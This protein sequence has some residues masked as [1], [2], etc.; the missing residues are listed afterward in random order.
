M[1]LARRRIDPAKAKLSGEALA[2]IDA[3][4][5]AEIERN[6]REDLDNP[7]LTAEELARG[8]FGR[9]VRK[10]RVELGLSQAEFAREFEL[11]VATVRDWEQGRTRPGKTAQSFMVL[12]ERMSKTALQAAPSSHKAA[13]RKERPRKGASATRTARKATARQK[14]AKR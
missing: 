2:R 13:R 10:K 12:L 11:S 9:R 6:A 8:L 5:P 7:P 4:T 3:L 1:A 14:A